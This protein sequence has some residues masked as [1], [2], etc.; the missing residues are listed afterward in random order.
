MG[1]RLTR[2]PVLLIKKQSLLEHEPIAK[3]KILLAPRRHCE[4]A[5]PT[6][7]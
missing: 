2:V 4:E 5:E 6:R 7:P 3:N 1:E